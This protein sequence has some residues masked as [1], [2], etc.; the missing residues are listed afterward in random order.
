MFCL[1]GNIMFTTVLSGVVRDWLAKE[2]KTC[3]KGPEECICMV[4][5]SRIM[6]MEKLL[7][8]LK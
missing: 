6:E 2:L 1:M 7:K 8:Y 3:A 5:G 4:K